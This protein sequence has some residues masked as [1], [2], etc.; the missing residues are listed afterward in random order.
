[1][2]P[3]STG[4]EQMPESDTSPAIC[5]RNLQKRYGDKMVLQGIDLAVGRGE[6]LGY[7]GPNGAGKTTTVKILTGMLGGFDGSARVCGLDVAADPLAVKRRI[8]YVPEAGA[9]YEALTPMEFL[10]LCGRLF[11]LP[12]DAL[13]HKSI[14]L[15]RLFE[16]DGQR[17]ERMTTFSKGMKQKVLI[18][19]GLI[20]NP[21]VIFLDEPLS[22]LDANST[23]VV[24]ELIRRL[25]AAGR[26]VFYCS[27][28]MDVVER[29]CDRIVIIDQGRIVADGTFE[30]L[31]AGRQ[32]ASLER[33]F[34]QLTSAGGHE[35][36]ARRF[37]E[38]IS[39][40]KVPG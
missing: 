31:Q 10:S 35:A 29:V 28:M 20:H 34:T 19:A 16:L 2:T 37:V 6:V 7:I 1:M 17:D 38:I 12:D 21:E 39:G 32:D 4:S 24:K 9:L 8:G 33:I 30:S 27:H 15:L 5:V 3:T 22:G 26:T 18:T 13:R 11:G 14:E 36:T 25:S 23:V 40:E